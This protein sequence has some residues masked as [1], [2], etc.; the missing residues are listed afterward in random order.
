MF[1]KYKQADNQ[2]V[3]DCNE[4]SNHLASQLP[5]DNSQAE[6]AQAY[7]ANLKLAIKHYLPPYH[8]PHT[9]ED[10]SE[11]APH[12][13]SNAK[14]FG[15]ET[16]FIKAMSRRSQDNHSRSTFPRKREASLSQDDCN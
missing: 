14:H 7:V 4:H 6:R 1:A 9:L 13:G 12:I 16:A 2:S 15:T 5:E 8:I 10:A 3:K 11:M